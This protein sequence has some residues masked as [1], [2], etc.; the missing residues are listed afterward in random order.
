MV[1]YR[2]GGCYTI[3]TYD[4]LLSP[5]LGLVTFSHQK[6]S[7]VNIVN[8]YASTRVCFA[9][10]N[11]GKVFAWGYSNNYTAGITNADIFTNTATS[12]I[13]SPRD[14]NI[15]ISSGILS[16]YVTD[17]HVHFV[18]A[19]SIL[20]VNIYDSS[21]AGNNYRTYTIPSGYTLHDILLPIIVFDSKL[22]DDSFYPKLIPILHLWTFKTPIF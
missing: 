9:L 16:I 10:D 12:Y 2:G 14:V 8:I 4:S 15:Y 17:L 3:D 20:S 22:F 11:V 1:Q 21:S 18:K 7:I 6:N 19:G 5:K 13:T